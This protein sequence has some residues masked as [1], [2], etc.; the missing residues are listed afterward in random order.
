MDIRSL[1]SVIILLFCVHLTSCDTFRDSAPDDFSEAPKN[2]DGTWLLQA[3]SRNGI[4]ITNEYD[5]S[6]FRLNLHSNGNYTIDNYLPFVVKKDGSWRT[7]DPLYPF[8]LIFT[9]E[10]SDDE[11]HLGLDY[12]I[13]N[14]ERIITVVL[15]PG[16]HRN[17]YIYVFKMENN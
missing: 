12:P 9:E 15:S 7:D 3:V 11:V 13:V 8:N 5:Y 17:S 10:G 4:D 2:M 14:G 6:E 16:C 1:F